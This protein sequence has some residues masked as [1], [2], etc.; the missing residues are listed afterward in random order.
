ME[1]LFTNEGGF[2]RI[3]PIVDKSQAYSTLQRFLYE[4]GVP[5][6]LMTDNGP[7]LIQGEWKGLCKKHNIHM[8]FI[9][10][11]S[12]WQNF[13]ELAGGYIKKNVRRLMQSTNTPMKL[14]DYC[15]EYFSKIK[16]NTATKKI[17]LG[18]RTPY[19]SVMGIR[20]D[21]I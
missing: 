5:L 15:W 1:Q 19:E 2:V 20:V 14:W 9:E 21:K 10:P 18:D 4:V 16:S 7:E 17:Y 13:A 8:K 6:I 11:H 12:S 3:Y